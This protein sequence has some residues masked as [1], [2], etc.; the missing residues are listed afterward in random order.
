VRRAVRTVA[1]GSAGRECCGHRIGESE[2]GTAHG[3]SSRL[4][5]HRPARS[6]DRQVA[7][8]SH[9]ITDRPAR[10]VAVGGPPE[11][12][13]ARMASRVRSASRPKTFRRPASS[14]D[15]AMRYSTR[16]RKARLAHPW[17]CRRKPIGERLGQLRETGSPRSA[18]LP[19]ASRLS[20]NSTVGCGA[21]R[22]RQPEDVPG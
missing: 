12:Q 6:A 11:A 8:D 16:A 9:G 15:C 22:P 3:D 20:V 2:A 14:Q 17:C 5:K 21:G 4:R 13:R 10:S 7:G 19:A 1:R 18:A